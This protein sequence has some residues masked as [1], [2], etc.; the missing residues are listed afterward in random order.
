MRGTPRPG[1]ERVSDCLA[2]GGTPYECGAPSSPIADT[3]P[4]D[5]LDLPDGIHIVDVTANVCP[6]GIEGDDMCSSVIGNVIVWY[7][8]SHL[9]NTF[10]ATLA[11]LIK[12]QLQEQAPWLF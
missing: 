7:D 2:G 12:I 3:N 11:P 8:G 5:S 1:Q 9:T 10:A 6:E 4:L